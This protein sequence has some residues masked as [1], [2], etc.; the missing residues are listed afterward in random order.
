MN[1]LLT[2][3][4]KKVKSAY[5]GFSRY[6]MNEI[7]WTQ[8]LILILGHRGAGKTTLLLQKLREVSDQSIYLSLDDFYF[9]ENPL[10]ILIDELY[11]QGYRHFYFDEVHRYARWSKDLKNLRDN[12]QDVFFVATG[13]SI[14]DISQ[15]SAD[16]SRRAV[17]YRLPGMSLR[18]FIN[19]ETGQTIPKLSLDDI[20]QNHQ[21]L[22]VDINDQINP[23]QFFA[24]YLKY[25]YFPFYKEG[26]SHYGQ[27]IQQIIRVVIEM[28]IGPFEGLSYQTVRNM[29]QLLRIISES[30]P[31]IP[32]VSKL[33]E[34]LG[35]SRNSV[36]KMLDLLSR[37]EIIAL[38][39]KDTQGV[40]YLQK[41]EKVYLANTNA[42]FALT[43]HPNIGNL[44][45]T[46]FLNQLSVNH[47]VGSPK[48]GDF[49]V[50][51]E[52]VF[53]IGGATKELEQIRGVPQAYIAADE[54]KFG[55]GRKIPLWMFGLLY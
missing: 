55:Q 2:L 19:F 12:Y 3:S 26:L 43:D 16:L 20:V 44:R 31:F 25:G 4:E 49:I 14:L 11:T 28:D 40:S 53:E 27:K 52:Y 21:Q 9:E 41:P 46:F 34:K 32:N 22:S 1:R 5:S 48:F 42:A 45:E 33:A 13:S 7:D 29:E 8:R 51:E 39:K 23:Q 6:L 35:S 38:L 10:I 17:Q 50:D 15:G 37:A 18:E 24:K 47:H 54:I 30:V 36:L